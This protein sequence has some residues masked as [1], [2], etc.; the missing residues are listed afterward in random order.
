MNLLSYHH[1]RD[2][3]VNAQAL[4]VYDL[5]HANTHTPGIAPGEGATPILHATKPYLE[6]LKPPGS[7][8]DPLDEAG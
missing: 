3:F 8:E 4:Q 6:A 7:C 2:F 5:S 1:C